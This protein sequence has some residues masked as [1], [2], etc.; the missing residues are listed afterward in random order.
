MASPP[1]FGPIYSLSRVELETLKTWLEDNLS[2]GFI[3]S[4]SSPAGTPILFVKKSDGSLRLCVDYRGLNEGTIRNRYPL[5]LLRETL[6]RLQ[7]A[8]FYT[9][10][11]VRGAYN[12]IRV[13]EGE[14][15]KTAFR[16]RYGLFET[17]VMPFGLTNAPATFQH[18][19][20]DVLRPFLD[21]FATAYLDDI[22]IY[23]ESLREHK[24][25][26]RQVLQA[27]S[28]A[29]LHLAPEKCEFHRQSVKY[30][31]FIIT[32][33]GVAPDPAKVATVQEWGTDKSPIRNR[34]DVQRFLGFANFYRRFIRDYS[35]I[36]S[37]L[38]RLTGKD[39][40]FEWSP[41]CSAALDTLKTA[42]TTAPVLRHFDHEREIL[43]ETDAS[44]FVSAGVLSQRDDAGVLH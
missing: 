44:D 17:L 11:D 12:L 38:T 31:G 18:F 7:K 8:K 20:N 30:L 27:L 34:T 22:L 13:A 5:P 40:P 26:V 2:K 15:W 6:L 10:L 28:D 33:E 41:E 35:R 19:I 24:R 37:P 3:R 16:T 42:F 4:S 21:I 29:G 23:S 43:V 9:K 36:V 14:E 32:T 39:V 25:H 1:P